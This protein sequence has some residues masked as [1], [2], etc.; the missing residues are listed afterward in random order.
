MGGSNSVINVANTTIDL[1]DYQ[2]S[3][4]GLIL[5]IINE[6]TWPVWIRVSIYLCGLLYLF[7]GI[8]KLSFC[9]ICFSNF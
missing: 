1:N 9:F 2:C 4:R 5:P 7:L 3:N 6:Y 8:G